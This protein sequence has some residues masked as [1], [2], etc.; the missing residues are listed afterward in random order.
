MIRELKAL[1]LEGGSFLTWV[2]NSGFVALK[3]LSLLVVQYFKY[4]TGLVL[5]AKRLARLIKS[6]IT[7]WVGSKTVQEE[8]KT[9]KCYSL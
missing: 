2:R 5:G 7:R 6:I 9:V 8:E 4:S 1:G 3:A